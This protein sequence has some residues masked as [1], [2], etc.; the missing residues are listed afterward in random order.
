VVVENTIEQR[1]EVDG[2]RRSEWQEHRKARTR[3]ALFESAM[4][5]FNTQGYMGT[6]VRQISEN[7]GFA[8]RTFFLHFPTKADVLF[9]VPAEDLGELTQLV[10]G[11]AHA[12]DDIEAVLQAILIW[13]DNRDTL[14]RHPMVR[15]MKEASALSAAIRGRELDYNQRLVDA[16]AT[17]L[18]IRR[19]EP[20]LDLSLHSRITAAVTMR[21][22]HL[23][24]D[25]W[26]RSEPDALFTIVCE[27][28]EVCRKMLS[29]LSD[30]PSGRLP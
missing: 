26:S 15:R 21:L 10:S 14:G 29:E 13:H 16:V 24:I 27:H 9:D 3:R 12:L 5:L 30:R 6:T 23:S 19:G 17:G 22:L 8:E 2:A 20:A 4:D 7:A 25:E 18:A 28:F 1:D 11:Q